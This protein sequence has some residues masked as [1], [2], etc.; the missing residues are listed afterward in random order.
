MGLQFQVIKW[1]QKQCE[2]QSLEVNDN[3]MRLVVGPLLYLIRFPRM[4]LEE[5]ASVC[6]FSNLLTDKEKVDIFI[7][8]TSSVKPE[9]PFSSMVIVVVLNGSMQISLLE[10]MRNLRKG[11][12]DQPLSKDW[13]VWPPC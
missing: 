9:I 12:V 6:Q 8:F 3:N 4:T 2:K 1:A 5:F 11:N 10:K 13:K 7:H